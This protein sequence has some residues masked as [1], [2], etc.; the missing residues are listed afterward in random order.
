[1]RSFTP[2]GAICVLL[3]APVAAQA[4]FVMYIDDLSTS[5]IDVIVADGADAGTA[6]SVGNTTVA[7]TNTTTGAVTFVGSTTNFMVTVTSGF[8]KPV[9]GDAY[10]AIMD[11]NYS[12]FSNPAGTFSDVAPTIKVYLTDTDFNLAG[13]PDNA[14]LTQQINGNFVGASTTGANVVFETGLGSTNQ[15]FTITDGMTTQSFTSPPSGYSASETMGV[16][17]DNP[18]SLTSVLSFT[19][20]GPNQGTTGDAFV[21]ASVPEPASFGI[22]GLGVLGLLGV[23]RRRRKVGATGVS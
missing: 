21:V 11:L 17:A 8:S 1:M 7:D 6:T 20:T 18:F 9:T 15:E 23:V 22:W 4:A 12:L 3:A 14:V 10:N 13:L 19:V 2:L 5:G 16:F